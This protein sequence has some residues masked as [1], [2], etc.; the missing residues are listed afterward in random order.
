MQ[1]ALERP[2]QLSVRCEVSE[3]KRG[4]AHSIKYHRV[5]LPRV[6]IDAYENNFCIRDG[7]IDGDAENVDDGLH[8]YVIDEESGEIDTLHTF[9]DTINKYIYIRQSKHPEE[10]ES[11]TVPAGMFDTVGNTRG[12]LSPVQALVKDRFERSVVRD[13]VH[14]MD[15]AIQKRDDTQTSLARDSGDISAAFAD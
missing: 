15:L 5:I 10:T 7:Y 3:E 6:K 11:G 12:G 14:R 4:Q 13:A 8:A 9:A 2:S 1:R